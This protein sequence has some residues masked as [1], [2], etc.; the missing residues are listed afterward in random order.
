MA[1]SYEIPNIINQGKNIGTCNN[2]YFFHITTGERIKKSAIFHAQIGTKYHE[3]YIR[4][5]NSE[6]LNLKCI[7]RTCPARELVKVRQSSLITIKGT[8]TLKNGCKRNIFQFD[9]SSP[10]ARV[11]TNYIFCEKTSLPHTAHALSKLKILNPVRKDL[12]EKHI[13]LGL[14]T[15]RSEVVRD[16]YFTMKLSPF[17]NLLVKSHNC[18]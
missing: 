3:Y 12:R 10:E 17:L 14:Q 11:L 13:L 5:V 6:T 4:Q 8:Q 16:F 15:R 2:P 18:K 9:F 7:D 1:T